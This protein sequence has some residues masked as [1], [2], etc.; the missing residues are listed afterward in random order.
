[1]EKEFSQSDFETEKQKER[2][3]IHDLIQEFR[4]VLAKNQYEIPAGTEVVMVLSAPPDLEFKDNPEQREKTPENISR[5]SF[6]HDI[7]KQLA[8]KK[9]NT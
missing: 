4:D 3:R 7:Y 8:A 1:M 6:A 2:E 9:L 5:I